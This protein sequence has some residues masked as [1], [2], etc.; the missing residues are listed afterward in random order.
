[1][2]TTSIAIMRSSRVAGLGC[3]GGAGGAG[4]AEAGAGLEGAASGMG[5]M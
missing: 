3:A 4:A 2:S 1:V 5:H